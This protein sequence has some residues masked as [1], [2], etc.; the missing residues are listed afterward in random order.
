V[1]INL[2]LAFVEFSI[3][4]SGLGTEYRRLLE[5]LPSDPALAGVEAILQYAQFG[6]AAPLAI[7]LSNDVALT[8]G[9]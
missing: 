2:A 7:T 5:H 8:V 9:H 1:Y 3:P 6:T 4:V